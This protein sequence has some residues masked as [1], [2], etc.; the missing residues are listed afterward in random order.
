MTLKLWGRPT[1]I[2]TQRALWAAAEAG[3][4]LDLTLASATMGPDGHVSQGG[5]PFGGVD[6]PA[7]RAMNPTGAIP[8]LEDE[9]R[10]VWDSAAI[11]V[12]LALAHAPKALIAD[13]VR[14]IATAVQWASWT[15][16]RLEP[17]MHELVMHC[18]RLPAA[19]REPACVAAAHADVLKALA[20]LAPA[21]QAA[22][23]LAGDRFTIAD[24]PAAATIYRWTLFDPPTA[25]PPP[26][27]AWLE[28]IRARDAFRLTVAPKDHHLA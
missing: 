1:S 28:R 17:A 19:E 8:T 23:W 22:E 4:P 18:V 9:G 20:E 6:Q 26:V 3:L 25:L 2:C 5:Q 24:I 10:V 11:L 21:L 12:H 27:A 15:N 13:D 7:Y 16:E 14:N